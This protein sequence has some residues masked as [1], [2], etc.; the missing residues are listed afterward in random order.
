MEVDGLSKRFSS[1]IV[2]VHLFLVVDLK[3]FS[4]LGQMEKFSNLRF[5]EDNFCGVFLLREKGSLGF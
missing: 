3:F 1:Q 4:F 2:I 5:V